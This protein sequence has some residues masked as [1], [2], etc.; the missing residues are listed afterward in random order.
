MRLSLL[1]C[2]LH[3]RPHLLNKL[4]WDLNLLSRLDERG[5]LESAIADYKDTRHFRML[6]DDRLRRYWIP[7]F[8]VGQYENIVLSAV[9]VLVSAHD[10]QSSWLG[11]TETPQA[12][13]RRM[14]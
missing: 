3:K 9:Y 8:A 10:D 2:S 12:W 14:R 5:W 1:V 4:L 7:L 13:L 11:L 6:H